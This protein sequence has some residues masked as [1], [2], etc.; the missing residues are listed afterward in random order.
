MKVVGLGV[1]ASI[2]KAAVVQTNLK[3]QIAA[4]AAVLGLVEAGAVVSVRQAQASSREMRRHNRAVN[5]GC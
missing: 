1:H 2:G 4:A 5:A 3:R